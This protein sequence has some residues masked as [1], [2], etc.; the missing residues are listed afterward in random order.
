MPLIFFIHACSFLQFY[1][2]AITCITNDLD[3][4]KQQHLLIELNSADHQY[5]HQTIV[6]RSFMSILCGKEMQ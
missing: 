2:S 4:F 5:T 1:T 3:S 6:I